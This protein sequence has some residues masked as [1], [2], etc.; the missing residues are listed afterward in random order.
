MERGGGGVDVVF[1]SRVFVYLYTCELYFKCGSHGIRACISTVVL[2]K[3]ISL[4]TRVMYLNV[5]YPVKDG[6]ELEAV[7]LVFSWIVAM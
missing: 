2:V 7:N 3:G 1:V 5:V 6:V 4:C